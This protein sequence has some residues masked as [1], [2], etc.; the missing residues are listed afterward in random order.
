MVF[1]VS[2][3]DGESNVWVFVFW[4]GNFYLFY[5]SQIDLSMCIFEFDGK[6]GVVDEIIFDFGCYIVGVGV[7][8]C[9]LIQ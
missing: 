2:G 9:A 3:I 6:T 4:G 8:T 1:F 7:S 5:K